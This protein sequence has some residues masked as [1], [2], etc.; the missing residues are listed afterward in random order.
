HRACF[1]LGAVL[2]PVVHIY[3]AAELAFILRQSRARVLIV[4]DR[5]RQIDFQA[6]IGELG[7]C[8]DLSHIVVVGEPTL[9]GAHSW[10]RLM[11]ADHEPAR[12]AHIAP[13]ATALLLYTSG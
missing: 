4:P 9:A 13:D 1:A 2:T 6:R 11:D 5:W 7:D 3:G 12:S 10:A 8:P